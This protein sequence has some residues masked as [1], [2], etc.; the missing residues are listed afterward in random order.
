MRSRIPRRDFLRRAVAAPAALVV[1]FDPDGR[2]WIADGRAAS[3]PFARL[4][5]LHGRLLFDTATLATA[6]L[7]NGNIVHRTPRAVL[8]AASADDVVAMVRFANQHGLRIAMRGQGHSVYGQAQ[9]EAGIVVDSTTLGRVLRVDGDVVE[10]EAGATWAAINEVT[11]SRGLTPRVTPDTMN[12][13]VGGGASV[14]TWGHTSHRF[15]A[16]VDNVTALDVVTGD[17]RLV[18]CSADRDPELFEMVLGGLGQCALIVRARVRLNRVP[19]QV[20]RQRLLYEDLDAF[21]ADQERLM[22]RVDHLEGRFLP[23]AAGRWRPGIDLAVF[24]EDDSALAQAR[25]GLRFA[26]AEPPTRLTFAEYLSRRAYVPQPESPVER[27]RMRASR[28]NPSIVMWLPR[29]SAQ[30]IVQDALAAASA[31]TTPWAFTSTLMDTTLFRRPLFRM[32]DGRLAISLWLLRSVP[33]SDERGFDALMSSSRVFMDRMRAT[34]G[35]CYPPYGLVASSSEWQ[36]HYGPDVWP[37][38]LRAKQRFDPNHVLTP[39]PGIFDR[40]ATR[41]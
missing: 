35:K 16:L 38:F 33:A 30:A 11:L 8:Q 5:R 41:P 12:L 39:G 34:G 2:N 1:G 22:G 17:G 26:S 37:R 27:D 20:V 29:A 19:E 14:G 13:T 10:A 18:S 6:A 4:P 32:P 24:S 15:G 40:S 9:V 25:N 28:R 31:L 7:D 36:E 21:Y 3:G 23:D